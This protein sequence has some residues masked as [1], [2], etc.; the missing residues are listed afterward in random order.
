MNEIFENDMDVNWMCGEIKGVPVLVIQSTGPVSSASL[1]AFEIRHLDTRFLYINDKL[2]ELVPD[3]F[4]VF[5]QGKITEPLL[6][7]DIDPTLNPLIAAIAR[8]QTW[9]LA[10]QVL[11]EG[12]P[13]TRLFTVDPNKTT[14]VKG[15][16][17]EDML[18]RWIAKLV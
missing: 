8:K 5:D 6:A 17:G 13:R 18:S 1:A 9:L 2:P 15:P 4:I 3:T 10:L 7:T 11:V 16:D 14:P 12:E